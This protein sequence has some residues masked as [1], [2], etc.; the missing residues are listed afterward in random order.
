MFVKE[1]FFEMV[2]FSKGFLNKVCFFQRGLFFY[3]K[4]D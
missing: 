1:F 4:A 3:F 2:F